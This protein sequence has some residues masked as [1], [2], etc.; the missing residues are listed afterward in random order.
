MDPRLIGRALKN[1]PA[2]PTAT[3]PFTFNDIVFAKAKLGGRLTA[4]DS[5]APKLARPQIDPFHASLE[6]ALKQDS[7]EN[8]EVDS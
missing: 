8:E 5:K 4:S 6:H 1:P 2:A 7:Q 3:N